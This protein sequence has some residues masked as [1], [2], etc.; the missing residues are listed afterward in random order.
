V[1]GLRSEVGEE[2]LAQDELPLADAEVRPEVAAGE[3]A[4]RGRDVEPEET[5]EILGGQDLR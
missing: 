5:R 4:A 3:V 1:D 2:G